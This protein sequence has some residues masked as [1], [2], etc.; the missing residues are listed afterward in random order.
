M[1]RSELI[2]RIHQ[3]QSHLP[4]DDMET[5]VKCM[6]GHIIDELCEGNRVEIRGFGAF[7]LHYRPPRLA[8]NPRTGEKIAKESRYAVHFKPGKELRERVN[9]LES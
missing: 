9:R 1:T 3:K 7:S 4:F 2:Q 8:R 6:I 5:A